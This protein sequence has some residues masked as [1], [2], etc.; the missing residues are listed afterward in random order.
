MDEIKYSQDGKFK[1]NILVVGITGCGKTTFVQN[2][3]KSNCLAT[4]K[5]FTGYQKLNFLKTE[6]KY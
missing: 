1:V 6:R 2:L 4:K 3:G 5:M